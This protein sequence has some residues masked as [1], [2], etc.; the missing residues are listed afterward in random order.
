MTGGGCGNGCVFLPARAGRGACVR[1]GMLL[2]YDLKNTH[3]KLIW[4]RSWENIRPKVA[5]LLIF[6]N[7]VVCN[8]YKRRGAEKS[9]PKKKTPEGKGKGGTYPS[10]GVPAVACH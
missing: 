3:I 7:A 10:N 9:A 8:G 4:T 1:L 6:K 5:S 2:T